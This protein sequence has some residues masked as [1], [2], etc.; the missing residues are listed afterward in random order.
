MSDISCTVLAMDR[1]APF[2]VE[3]RPEGLY[4]P[5]IDLFLDPDREVGRA[6]VSHAHGDHVGGSGS[7]L[8]I[9]SPETLALVAARGNLTL[10]GERVLGWDESMELPM[11]GGGHVRLS[12]A[13]AGHMLGAAQLVLD[14]PRF[15]LVYTGDYRTGCGATHATGAPVP[16]DVLIIESTFALPIFHFP[17]RAN[18]LASLVSWCRARLDAGEL[19]VVIAYALGK[20]QELIHWLLE[21]DLPLIAH[22]AVHRMC[23]A[24]ESHGRVL[25]IADGRLHA[26]VEEKKRDKMKGVLVV[27]PGVQG[28]PMI[29]KRKDAHIAYVSGW[30]TIDAAIEQQR[31]DAGF[32]ISDHADWDDL[33][34]TVQASGARR[35]FVTHGDAQ[36]LA[37][38]LSSLGIEAT[39]IEAPSLDAREDAT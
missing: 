18:T 19:P 3:Q 32:V 15:R 26:Y 20:S 24:Y 28:Q 29:K 30:A 14:H 17:D 36:V 22:G 11:E 8:L 9:G 37:G 39:A 21:A 34:S 35:V 5:A 23:A 33:L 10:P 6:F 2:E 38:H 13:P 27:P 4:L 1:F 16:C 7:G 25:G 31:A 12:I